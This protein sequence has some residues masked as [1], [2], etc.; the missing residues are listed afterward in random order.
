MY[1]P[2]SEEVVY[3][4]KDMGMTSSGGRQIHNYG[5]RAHAVGPPD[6]RDLVQ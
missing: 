1:L 5:I 3:L 6:R 4:L 2:G